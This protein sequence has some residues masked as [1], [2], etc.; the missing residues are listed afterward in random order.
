MRRTFASVLAMALAGSALAQTG[1]VARLD[2]QYG[3]R[4]LKFEQSI[5]SVSDAVLLE[6]AGDL[7]FYSRKNDTLEWAGAR[8]KTIEY[9]FY[10]GKLANI[11]IAAADAAEAEKLLK[12]WQAEYG[13]GRPSPSNPHKLYWFGEKVL[14]DYLPSPTGPA[15]IGLWSKPLQAVRRA[16]QRS[17]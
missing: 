3:F 6:D 2:E 9:G 5:K 8:L 10:K 7:K 1:S 15:S 12:A 17:K 16:A 14:A 13:S 11:T 4:D